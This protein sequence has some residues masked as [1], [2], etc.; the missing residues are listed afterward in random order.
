MTQ[1]SREGRNIRYNHWLAW[2]ANRRSSSRQRND[3]IHDHNIPLEVHCHMKLRSSKRPLPFR[4][5]TGGGGGGGGDCSST[6][7]LPF[8]LSSTV[9]N[10]DSLKSN[11]S[12]LPMVPLKRQK[13]TGWVEEEDPTGDSCP[14]LV[15]V[16]QSS[17]LLSKGEA[18]AS[19][20]E[21]TLRQE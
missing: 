20:M 21:K 7:V 5:P 15:A 14:A 12:D 18:T 8:K 4:L 17:S 11:C 19:E 13:T 9:G 10:E 2:C 3:L 1:S 16:E 6:F